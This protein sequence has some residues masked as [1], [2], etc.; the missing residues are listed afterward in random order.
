MAPPESRKWQD[1]PGKL[2]RLLGELAYAY[3]QHTNILMGTGHGTGDISHAAIE[4]LFEE[5][6]QVGGPEIL[7]KID[8]VI[9]AEPEGDFSL[10]TLHKRLQELADSL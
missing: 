10:G 6:E 4:D 1:P 2:K 7:E 8:E 3:P 5:I 9:G